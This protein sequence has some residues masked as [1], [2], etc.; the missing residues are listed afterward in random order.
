[1]DSTHKGTAMRPYRNA[2]MLLRTRVTHQYVTVVEYDFRVSGEAPRENV[3]IR[4]T[5]VVAD[6]IQ[7]LVT[8]ILVAKVMSM[9]VLV[10]PFLT[11]PT[12]R[13][14]GYPTHVLGPLWCFTAF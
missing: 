3:S 12:R 8:E 4:V 10:T 2:I 7:S 14:R 13:C 11:G 1:M 5:T 6:V 9:W